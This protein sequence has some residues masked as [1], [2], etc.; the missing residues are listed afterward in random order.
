[1]RLT[2][3]RGVYSSNTFFLSCRNPSPSFWNV[4]RGSWCCS[5]LKSSFK[6][7]KCETLK[8]WRVHEHRQRSSFSVHCVMT[9]FFVLQNRASCAVCDLPAS[10]STGGP[11][12]AQRF[13]P[14]FS[15]IQQ[16][17]LAMFKSQI[18]C[19]WEASFAIL[20]F[21]CTNP[22]GSGRKP[23]LDELVL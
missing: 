5:G 7:C 21:F 20:F 13:P 4:D 15:L 18:D 8:W 3:I 16:F 2:W 22:A 19:L 10:P 11:R 1:M 9:G 23:L 17:K 12:V 14:F 6:M